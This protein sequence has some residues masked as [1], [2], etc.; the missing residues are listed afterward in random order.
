MVRASQACWLTLLLAAA[1]FGQPAKSGWSKFLA[2]A[3]NSPQGLSPHAAGKLGM[4]IDVFYGLVAAPAI[5]PDG[6][7]Y[8][9]ESNGFDVKLRALSPAGSTKWAVEVAGFA[10]YLDRP[11]LVGPTGII[12]LATQYDLYAISPQGKVLWGQQVGSYPAVDALGTIYVG[13]TGDGSGYQV[14]ALNLDGAVKWTKLVQGAAQPCVGKDGDIYVGSYA[15]LTKLSPTGEILWTQPAPWPY[16]TGGTSFALPDGSI[17]VGNDSNTI[18]SVPPWPTAFANFS[19]SGKLRWS[20]GNFGGDGPFG[21]MGFAPSPNGGMYAFGF[22]GSLTC[23]SANGTRLWARRVA[24]PE[25]LPNVFPGLAEL[26]TDAKGNVVIQ[27]GNGK[28]WS[29]TADGRVRWSVQ[30]SDGVSGAPVSGTNGLIYVASYSEVTPSASSSSLYAVSPSGTLEWADHGSNVDSVP[31]FGADGTAYFSGGNG[32]TAFDS[33]GNLK[34]TFGV[35]AVHGNR[36]GNLGYGAWSTQ[37][38]VGADGTIYFWSTDGFR[39][40]TPAGKLK[41]FYPHVQSSTTE[42]DVLDPA[43]GPDGTI[44]F[45]DQKLCALNADGSL[46]WSK[47]Y[48]DWLK[49]VCPVINADGTLYVISQGQTSPQAI[50]AIA[51]DGTQLWTSVQAAPWQTISL[52]SRGNLYTIVL[53]TMTELSSSGKIVNNYGGSTSTWFVVAS[54]GTVC[55]RD[56]STNDIL[57]NGGNAMGSDWDPFAIASDDTIYGITKTGGTVRAY[58]NQGRL[59]WS[60]PTAS[61][62]NSQFHSFPSPG[63]PQLGSADRPF[64]VAPD[65]S[66]YVRTGYGFVVVN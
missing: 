2:N 9:V 50:Y 63:V 38:T 59:I 26:A 61:L 12:Y 27:D 11:P 5:G 3:S 48:G 21:C 4:T 40:V 37:P 24:P 13:G 54:D 46:K 34:W 16:A 36:L 49:A 19:A 29:F 6:T 60:V 45:A 65:G 52:D 62:W 7:V 42:D 66:L 53:N 28:L 57:I 43:I 15:G 25:P 64:S 56:S 18:T 58:N 22:G 30:L 51:A 55:Y 1:G 14:S 47:A 32:I 33:G 17:C 20:Y 41:W 10:D 8:V 44:Y 39:A 31:S 23:L 35:G